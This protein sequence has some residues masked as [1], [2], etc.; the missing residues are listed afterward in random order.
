M[1]MRFAQAAVAGLA[2]TIAVALL[3]RRNPGSALPS[4]L[5]AC[6]APAAAAVS[7]ASPA[8]SPAGAIALRWVERLQKESPKRSS[9]PAGELARSEEREFAQ[10]LS[11]N[12]NAEPEQWDV[13]LGLLSQEDPRMGRHIV[14][15]LRDSLNA[16]SEKR[17]I[18]LL[19]LAGHR[20]T[21]MA[22]ANLL[23]SRSS[24]DSLWALLAAAQEDA[25]SGVRYKALSEL[26][27]RQGVEAN[28]AN[29]QVI[30]QVL[31]VRAQVESD[32]EVRQF[33]LR[34]LGQASNPSFPGMNPKK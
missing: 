31:R 26:A 3:V 33:L 6:P 17:L 28:P 25:D 2:L 23:G 19:K 27:V 12:L 32:P 21:R 5:K 24:V 20:E 14:G 22:S 15:S 29:A 4:A 8:A 9:D 1:R 7:A 16:A 18:G 34:L 10:A 13:V 30:D 11:D